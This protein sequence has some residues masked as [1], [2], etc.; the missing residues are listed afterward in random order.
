[1]SRVVWARAASDIRP[2]HVQ[3]SGNF[4]GSWRTRRSAIR[5][6]RRLLRNGWATVTVE[7]VRIALNAEAE[8]HPFRPDCTPEVHTHDEPYPPD[9]G[10]SD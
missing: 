4:M 5:Q 3:A 9:F 6:A 7:D 2:F 10:T 8:W 1:M